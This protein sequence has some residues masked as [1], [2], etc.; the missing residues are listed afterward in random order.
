MSHDHAWFIALSY[1]ITAVAVLAT[2]VAIALK[3]R[4]L[5]K[6]LRQIG[7]PADERGE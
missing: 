2:I 7:A 1:G 3:H 6:A 5:K 4:R